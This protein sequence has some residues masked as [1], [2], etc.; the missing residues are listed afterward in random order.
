MPSQSNNARESLP[1]LQAQTAG[2][3]ARPKLVGSD[4]P[5]PSMAKP[6]E[7]AKYE[8]ENAKPVPASAAALALQSQPSLSQ[9]RLHGKFPEQIESL[10]NQHRA[11]L[12]KGFGSEKPM[13][14][15]SESIATS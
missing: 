5:V 11:P 3:R 14:D 4:A 1:S 13:N 6:S 2:L 10:V 8:T 9:M 7:P 12:M 15:T